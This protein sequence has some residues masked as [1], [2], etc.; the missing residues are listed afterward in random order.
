LKKS[1]VPPAVP[2]EVDH[3]ITKELDNAADPAILEEIVR[4]QVDL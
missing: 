4:H 2:E 3:I 1:S